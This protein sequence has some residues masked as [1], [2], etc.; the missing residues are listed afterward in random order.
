MPSVTLGRL[1]ID[2]F[3]CYTLERPWK[4]N[5]PFDSCIPEGF[6][7]VIQV[8]SPKFGDTY[9]VTVPDRTHILFHAANWVH[10]LHGCIATGSY[11]DPKNY[12]EHG[13]MISNSRVTHKRLLSTVQ[14][15]SFRLHITHYHPTFD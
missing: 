3:T 14:E 2:D 15:K 1:T 4:Q 6:Y 8:D 9:E 11:V 12:T 10:Q 7:P 5:T 13:A